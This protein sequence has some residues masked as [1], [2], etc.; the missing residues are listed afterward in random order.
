VTGGPVTGAVRRFA[1]LAAWVRTRAPRLGPVRVVAVDGP[2]GAGKTAFAERLADA[3]REAG[4]VVDQVHTDDLLDGWDDIVE[5]W[6]RLEE[7]ILG[8][9]GRGEPASYRPYD[10]HAGHFAARPVG[11]PVPEVLVLEGVTSA[12]AAIRD[13]LALSVL[14]TAPAP[15]RLERAV[16]RDGEALRPHLLRWMRTEAA[17][18]A[19]DATAEHADLLVDGAPTIAH[20]PQ[21][22][23]VCRRACGPGA[24]SRIDDDRGGRGLTT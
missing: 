1:D 5:F 17:H 10:W 19:A 20:D 16:A 15:V 3:L 4:A 23:Y 13:R 18:F 8:P 12:R 7:W 21:M 6:P 24:G 14:V 9:L 2:T 11:V 22:E